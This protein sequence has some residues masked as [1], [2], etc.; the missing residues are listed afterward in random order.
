M[1]T[2]SLSSSVF[3]HSDHNNRAFAIYVLFLLILC[4][5]VSRYVSI[6]LSSGPRPLDVYRKAIPY[7]LI[8]G[9]VFPLIVYWTHYVREPGQESFPLYYYLVIVVAYGLH[10]VNCLI[11]R[12]SCLFVCLFIAP[13]L[14][15]TF[16]CSLSV[17]IS[18]R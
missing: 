13:N 8:F 16:I 4:F 5:E 7:R 15:H 9:F 3:R 10:Q 11:C 14:V 6:S 1:T 12:V 18:F 17:A 2:S